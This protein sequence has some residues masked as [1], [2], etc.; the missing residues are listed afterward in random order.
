MRLNCHIHYSLKIHTEKKYTNLNVIKG[1]KH[2]KC[3]LLHLSIV[4][5]FVFQ[6]TCILCDFLGHGVLYCVCSFPLLMVNSLFVVRIDL[7]GM[8]QWSRRQGIDPRKGDQFT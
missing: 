1:M 8:E 6:R 2:I 4:C 7:L 5:G 3:S